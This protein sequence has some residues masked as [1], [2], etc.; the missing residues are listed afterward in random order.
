MFGCSARDQIPSSLAL[1]PR[2]LRDQE[3]NP[4]LVEGGRDYWGDDAY[5]QTVG[6][7]DMVPGRL[8]IFPSEFYHSAYQPKDSFYDFPRLTLAFWMIS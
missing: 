5:W 6:S 4:A 7:I 8:I 2:Y 1:D 3:E